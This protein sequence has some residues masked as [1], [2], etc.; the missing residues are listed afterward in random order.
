MPTRTTPRSAASGG[1]FARPAPR[2]TSPRWSR[3]QGRRTAQS[4]RPAAPRGVTFRRR[5]PKRS[6][7]GKAIGGL[8]GLLPTSGAKSGGRGKKGPAGFAVL[9]GAAGLALKNRDKIT[10]IINRRRSQPEAAGV[11]DQARTDAGPAGTQSETSSVPPLGG[12]VPP[13]TP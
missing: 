10:S 5:P 6:T 13:T 8:A 1:R 11:G 2:S 4:R 3:P 12:P 7:A 9:A